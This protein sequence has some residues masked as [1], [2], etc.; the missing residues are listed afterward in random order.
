MRERNFCF[1]LANG[2]LINAACICGG[3]QRSKGRYKVKG[4]L[5]RLLPAYL[6]QITLC[7]SMAGL[8]MDPNL[9]FIL[10]RGLHG[11]PTNVVLSHTST[12]NLQR[13]MLLGKEGTTNACTQCM[14]SLSTDVT[15]Q[16]GSQNTGK[17]FSSCLGEKKY[18]SGTVKAEFQFLCI[19][20]YSPWHVKVTLDC[21]LEKAKAP[22]H[23]WGVP[24]SLHLLRYVKYF[25]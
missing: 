1:Y 3:L 13:G 16:F 7:S 22:H 2:E 4:T 15:W 18:E 19:S 21:E 14:Q 24:D 6:M 10:K 9:M 12:V 20:D 11:K 23:L 17:L 5:L 8:A 25:F